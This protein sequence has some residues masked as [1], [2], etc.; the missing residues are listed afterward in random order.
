VCA[1]LTFAGDSADSASV[2]MEEC[3]DVLKTDNDELDIVICECSRLLGEK[4]TNIHIHAHIIFAVMLSCVIVNH[5]GV[6]SHN[7]S[8]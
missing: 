7:Q 1:T 4:N 3:N 2:A 6:V 5:R 8:P